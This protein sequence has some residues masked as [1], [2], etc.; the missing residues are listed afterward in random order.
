M[1]SRYL[2]LVP[3]AGNAQRGQPTGIWR[4]WLAEIILTVEMEL[5]DGCRAGTCKWNWELTKLGPRGWE[6]WGLAIFL[7]RMGWDLCPAGEG[8]SVGTMCSPGRHHKKRSLLL[9]QH[10]LPIWM[11]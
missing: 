11:G 8:K 9:R 3:D 2:D 6:R 10:F 4:L 7:N 1:G 5:R